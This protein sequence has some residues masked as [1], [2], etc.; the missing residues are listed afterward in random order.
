MTTAESTAL[1]TAF[2]ERAARY[3][4]A[5]DLS[6]AHHW[7]LAADEVCEAECK[8]ITRAADRILKRRTRKLG[9]RLTR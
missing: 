2:R 4:A 8:S 3:R 7:S 5:G 9:L 6:A 1:E